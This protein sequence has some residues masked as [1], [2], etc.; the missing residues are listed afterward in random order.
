MKRGNDSIPLVLKLILFLYIHAYLCNNTIRKE[1]T[2][3]N[4]PDSLI[5]KIRFEILNVEF[6]W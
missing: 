2:Y 5:F 4:T 3:I 1:L 6:L